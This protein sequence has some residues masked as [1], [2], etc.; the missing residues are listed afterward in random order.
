MVP[1]MTGGVFWEHL[2]RL[3]AGGLIIFFSAATYLAW[4]ETPRFQWIRTW[5]LVGI[6]LLL[7]QALLG[8]ITVLYKLPDAISTSHLGLAFLF[9][10]LAT[11]LAVTSGPGWEGGPGPSPPSRLSLRRTALLATGLVFSQSLVGAAVRHTD[12]GMACPD[13]PLCLGRWIPPLDN[14]LVAL[15]FGHRLLGLGV[16][17]AVLWVG[18]LAFWK[19]G[20][21]R[22]KALGVWAS[23]LV[24]LQVLLGFLSVYD[25]LSVVPVSFHTLLAAT[26]LSLMAALTAL[27]WA[28]H[29]TEVDRNPRPGK[30]RGQ[31][32][33]ASRTARPQD[34]PSA[35]GGPK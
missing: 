18:H 9:L 6:L 12:A 14:G 30:L 25:R 26:L 19:S 21:R 32:H 27:T 13:V 2:H 1:E 23:I 29:S 8:G 31:G 20:S 15:H 28:P 34:A 35:T 11:V 10:S 5:A 4:R 3:V 24:L 22:L 17:A 7:I 33:G 16:L